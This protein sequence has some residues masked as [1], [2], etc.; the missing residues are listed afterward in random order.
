MCPPPTPGLQ[1]SGVTSDFGFCRRLWPLFT[2][3]GCQMGKCSP[4]PRKGQGQGWAGLRVPPWDTLTVTL[5]YPK[6]GA[7]PLPS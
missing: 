6:P 5:T 2:K 4:L 3:G 7:V 1:E